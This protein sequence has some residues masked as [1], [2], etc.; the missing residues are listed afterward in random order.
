MTWS[1]KTLSCS[2]VHNAM[3]RANNHA[4]GQLLTIL[5]VGNNAKNN[6][7]DSIHRMVNIC[8]C[9]WKPCLAQSLS[10]SMK[11]LSYARQCHVPFAHMVQGMIQYIVLQLQWK[12]GGAEIS[13]SSNSDMVAD[14]Y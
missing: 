2:T 3:M 13:L 12:R 1:N 14:A 7:L 6:G 10:H 4:K 9:C 5:L 11:F 8:C